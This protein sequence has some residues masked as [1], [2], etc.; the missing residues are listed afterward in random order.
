MT[1]DDRAVTQGPAPGHFQS[2]VTGYLRGRRLQLV[3]M[4]NLLARAVPAE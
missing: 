1:E 2:R 3:R 4:R